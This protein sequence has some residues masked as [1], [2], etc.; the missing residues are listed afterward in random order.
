MRYSK[1][2]RSS[3]LFAALNRSQAIISF[4][5]DGHITWANSNFL[6]LMGYDLS[7]VRGKHHGLF[8]DPQER[9]SAEYTA[10]WAALTSGKFQ[11][12]E[13]RRFT[14][15]GSEVWI[16]A[17]Y[18][19]VLNALGQVS[20]VVKLAT[21][22][23][24]EKM[25]AASARGQI[26]ALNK[27]QAVIEFDLQ[28]N[29]L[30]AN[31]NF[32]NA[33][34]YRG[35]EVVGRHHSL[36]VSDA[37]AASPEYAAFW[38]KLR[39]GDHHEG[40]FQ[41]TGKD[42]RN[43]WIRAS[44]N[45]VSDPA[46]RPWKVVKFATDITKEAL[47]AADATGKIL[48]INRAQAVIEFDL[49]GKILTANDNFLDAMGYTLD[50]VAGQHHSLFVDPATK[51]SA[52]YT[53]FWASL[54]TGTFQSAVYKRV[55]K[56]GREVWIQA[57][58]NPILGPD[59]TPLKVV[60]FATDITEQTL[61]TASYAGQVDAIS[62]SQAV[63][64]FDLDGTIL[65]ANDNFLAAM[66]YDLG[67]I[68][69]QHHRMFVDQTEAEGLE[70]K[71]FWTALR[72]GK[73]Q[74]AEFRRFGKG[75][76]EIWIQATYNPILDPAG[77][78]IKVVKFATDITERKLRD[79]SFQAKIEAVD[80]SQA[81]IEFDL[82]GI[83][84]SANDNFLDAMGYTRDEI[85]GKHHRMFVDKAY[86]ASQEYQALWQ[87]LQ[88]GKFQS[89]E[90][91]R[92]A[93][94]G[95]DVWIQG[96]YNPIH[97]PNGKPASVVKFANDITETVRNREKAKLL[98]LVTDETDNSV[99]I[100][101]NLGRIEYVNGGFTRMTGHS[102]AECVGK[103]P[104]KLLQGKH[105][106]RDTIAR[107]KNKIANC[108]PFYEEILNYTKSGEAYW[109]SLAINPVFASDGRVER[110]VSIQANIDS[111]KK[112]S[113]EHD[114]R[115]KAISATSAIAEWDATGNLLEQNDYL[116]RYVTSGRVRISEILDED[117]IKTVK[118][119]ETVRQETLW[120]LKGGS[121][122]ILDAVFNAVRNVEGQVT[123]VL[124]FAVDVTERNGMVNSA[125]QMM[126][127]SG[128]DISSIVETIQMIS[129]ETRL[130]SLNAS[131]EA[132]RAGDLGRGFAVVASEVR[133]L[134]EKSSNAARDISLLLDSNR[135]RVEALTKS[136]E[137][138][139][140]QETAGSAHAKSS[141]APRNAA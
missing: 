48:A 10:F 23:T 11:S 116:S 46:G 125:M 36:F 84:L 67:E 74:S 79:A 13:F 53:Q 73:F 14:K 132:A 40:E 51:A 85:I 129:N 96:A 21:D 35:E 112:Q 109:I 58:Y 133:G 101:D 69:G 49:E 60:K 3:S 44:Y 113:L 19:P 126:Q 2:G 25:R 30:T 110:F 57:T 130:L 138:G 63:I 108:E 134:A 9:A 37:Y 72:D 20:R 29:I 56:G 81:M 103:S 140:Q 106:D 66:G 7:E 65:T 105:T 135:E 71:A 123:K 50:E 137:G 100:T 16:Q 111:T 89:G 52:E 131:V 41:R 55:G 4:R 99:I 1:I 136:L 120:P 62:R 124:M 59:G 117:Q 98:S 54:R 42:G 102:F 45:P 92:I 115:L 70:Y 5:P 141:P 17:T 121:T 83:I 86:G 28:G 95:S 68:E 118:R 97:D 26:S 94:D 90:F 64:E 104:G 6:S 32:L 24:D 34:G 8:V 114:I 122:L 119:G 18:N 139:D 80:R 88:S 22:I 107:I 127:R 47:S 82:E 39:R 61:R 12:A 75:G 93:K 33:M 15:D 77:T 128:V 38:D 76:R 78:P 91:R 43:V 27:S 31:E 87:S